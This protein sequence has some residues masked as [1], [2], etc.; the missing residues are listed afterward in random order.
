MDIVLVFSCFV[1]FKV[2]T[3]DTYKVHFLHLALHTKGKEF[4]SSVLLL[5]NIIAKS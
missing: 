5:E 3:A 1:V 4:N 2:K